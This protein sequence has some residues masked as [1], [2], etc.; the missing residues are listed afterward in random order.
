MKHIIFVILALGSVLVGVGYADTE[1]PDYVGYHLQEINRLRAE[2]GLPPFDYNDNLAEAAGVQADWMIRNWSYAHY[3]GGSTP[4]TRA[5]DAGYTGYD[6]CCTENTFLSP[7]TTPEGAL[8]WW[9]QSPPHYKQLMSPEY[10]EIG[11]GFSIG[12]ART[13]Q[14]I[15]FGRRAPLDDETSSAATSPSSNP[16][17][18]ISSPPAEESACAVQHRVRSGENLFRIGL[19]YGF[20]AQQLARYNNI[21]DVRRIYAG[22]QLCIPADGQTI[23]RS[24]APLSGVSDTSDV[25]ANASTTTSTDNWCYPGNPW[26]DG[27]CNQST[28][29]AVRSYMWRCGW[30][31]AQ[32]IEHA[33]CTP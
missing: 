27:R 23:A 16:S 2:E 19:R 5:V 12:S 24:N 3:H 15:V 33:E 18:P 28:D 22:Q 4:T 20:S 21:A 26:G 7:T 10:D 8:G 6:W 29:P 30:Y 14:V 32:G 9:M 31:Y 17:T 25:S 13:A 1:T 11:V